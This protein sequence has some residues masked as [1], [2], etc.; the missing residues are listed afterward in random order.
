MRRYAMT[1]RIWECFCFIEKYSRKHLHF[2]Q[3]TTIAEHMGVKP[4]WVT[5]ML[6]VLI[7]EGYIEKTGRFSYRISQDYLDGKMK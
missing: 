7:R 2:P 4:L 1:E 3:A 5:K 6:M